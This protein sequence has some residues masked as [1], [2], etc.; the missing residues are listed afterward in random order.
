MEKKNLSDKITNEQVF[1][2]IGEK[3]TLQK[4]SYVENPIGL[5]TFLEEIAFFMMS[6]KEKR[7]K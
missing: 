7:R 1:E 2:R 6:M 3:W 5:V 4:L